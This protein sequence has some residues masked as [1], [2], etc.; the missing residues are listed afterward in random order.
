LDSIFPP[1]NSEHIKK[2]KKIPKLEVASKAIQPV[3]N[4]T[5]S[6]KCDETEIFNIV[7]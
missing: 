2:K 4:K 6:C 5:L 1:N 3:A 7:I